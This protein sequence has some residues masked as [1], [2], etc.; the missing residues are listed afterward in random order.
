[1]PLFRKKIEKPKSVL[2]YALFRYD[3]IIN[4]NLKSLFDTIKKNNYPNSRNVIKIL[5]GTFMSFDSIL[6]DISVENFKTDYRSDKIRYILSGMIE[7]VKSY[8]AELAKNNFEL[9]PS[10]IPGSDF[11]NELKETRDLVRKKMRDVESDYS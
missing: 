6:E 7:K 9:N 8:L 1:M 4:K 3:N 5:D 2:G 10:F 11:L